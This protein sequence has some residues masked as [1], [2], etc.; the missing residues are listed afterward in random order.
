MPYG[1]SLEIC[2]CA[3]F[4]YAADSALYEWD[5]EIHNLINTMFSV[6][7]GKKTSK[8]TEVV[9]PTVSK[10]VK[11]MSVSQYLTRTQ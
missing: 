4:F 1:W 8:I 6:E 3:Y 5:T 11:V 2:A 7:N 9:Q 10:V